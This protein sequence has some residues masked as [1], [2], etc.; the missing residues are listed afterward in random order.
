[1]LPDLQQFY[2]RN[3][4]LNSDLNVITFQWKSARPSIVTQKENQIMEDEAFTP[5]PS[6]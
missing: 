3:L 5:Q 2:L 1:M 4:E 6:E